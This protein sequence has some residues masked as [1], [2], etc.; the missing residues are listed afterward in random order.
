MKKN[1]FKSLRVTWFFVLIFFGLAPML[2]ADHVMISKMNADLIQEQLNSIQ[3][4]WLIMANEIS[5]SGYL[6]GTQ[7]DVV[8]AEIVQFANFM[9]GRAVVVNSSYRIIRDTYELDTG[10]Y[11]IS[12]S[13]ILAF[14][15]ESVVDYSAGADHADLVQPVY[16]AE[17][18]E[19]I[20]VIVISLPTSSLH[21][22][23]TD[24]TGLLAILETVI[25]AVIVVLAFVISGQMVGPF[26]RIAAKL[27]YAT[28]N[29]LED[30]KEEGYAE[31]RHIY[32]TYNKT[33][34]R[35]RVLD[36]SRQ[37]FVSNVSH[38]L[39]TP[40]ASMRVLADSLTS[41]EDVP[42]E[43]YREFMQDISEE[44]DR[45][46]NIID[47]LL[48]LVKLD[49]S[50]AD[51]NIAQVNVNKLLEATLKRLRPIAEQKN[52]E[53]VLES[54]RPVTADID[55]TKFS[56]AIM[57][58]VENAI[59]YNVQGGWVHVSLNADHKYMYIKVADSGIGIPEEEQDHIFE[60]FYRVDKVRSREAGGTGL[61]LAITKSIIFLHHGAIKVYS[62]E[63]E[64]STF[65]VRVPLIYIE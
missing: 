21:D 28:D 57:N 48:T 15:G 19:V 26:R 23:T 34:A 3:A 46:S 44:I 27:A 29:P 14:S 33:L 25:A 49:K 6:D 64:G 32:E 4:Q 35:M 7:N 43:I 10:K 55:E 11:N 54:F 45:E 18:T 12:E 42:N 47:D 37:Q 50:S 60:R 22:L 17:K 63:N 31:T 39:K 58:L 1:R 24:S 41:Q 52:V 8:D 2:I 53:L 36:E 16:N 40:L 38:E 9:N 13:V 59:K 20:G 51:L 5:G 62:S 56:L 65:T 30:V 61:G